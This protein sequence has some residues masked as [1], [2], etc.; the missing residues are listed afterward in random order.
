MSVGV[1]VCMCMYMCM[2][3]CICIICVCVRAC[4]YVCVHVCV[5]VYE[6]VCVHS[7][8]SACRRAGQYKCIVSMIASWRMPLMCGANSTTMTLVRICAYSVYKLCSAP[9][10]R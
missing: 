6:R 1:H 5:H 7:L 3:M 8:W 4:T 10:V 9:E 2:Y